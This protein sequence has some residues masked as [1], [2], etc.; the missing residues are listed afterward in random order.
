MHKPPSDLINTIIE[1]TTSIANAIEN[2][3]LEVPALV[4]FLEERDSHFESL[5][6]E[7]DI[8]AK[9]MARL[10]RTLAPYDQVI[11][12]WCKERQDHIVAQLRDRKRH[13]TPASTKLE[14]QIINQDA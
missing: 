4:A 8:D 12:N 9:E 3:D 11:S 1:S 6:Q 7:A 13:R 14:A 2:A 10:A 5:R